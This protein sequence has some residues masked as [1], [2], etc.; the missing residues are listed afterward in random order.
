MRAP[1]RTAFVV[2][3]A[4][5]WTLQ[6]RDP[7]A[8]GYKAAAAPE[9]AEVLAVPERVPE[10][11]ADALR[12]VWDRM[13]P[14]RDYVVLGDPM[15]GEPAAGLLDGHVA[16]AHA[17]ADHEHEHHEDH[18]GDHEHGHGDHDG[19]HDHHDM[20]AI[21]GDPSADGLIMEAVDFSLGPF[22]PSLPGG[23]VVDLSL[24]GDVLARAR[25]RA[26]LLLGA[27]DHP[28]APLTWQV[29][30]ARAR[31]SPSESTGRRQIVA[32]EAERALSHALSLSALAS[33]MGWRDLSDAA[34]ELRRELLSLRG[35]GAAALAGTTEDVDTRGAERA[36]ARAARLL[37]RRSARARLARRG[38]LDRATVEEAKVG[39]PIGRATG[40]EDD[41]RTTDAL[42]AALD[43]TPETASA[44]DAAARVDVRVR[45]VAASLRLVRAAGAEE[46]SAGPA[47][48]SAAGLPVTVEGPRGPVMAIAAPD[49]QVAVA[50]PGAE[51]T[52]DLAGHAV[53][54][55]E[56]GPAMVALASFD[57]DPWRVEA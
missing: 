7:F 24:D 51:A 23:L 8:D 35:R 48:D 25:V 31:T 45:E 14:P 39:G 9:R 57:L 19:G 16:E 3:D 36:L 40:F 46:G 13:A 27:A 49:E 55:L 10:G 1:Q 2:P 53:V 4:A 44:G 34:Y 20:M 30:T 56:M 50:T 15:G 47:Q 6:G 21:V 29:A 52:L 17:H 41:A 42:Y 33:A 5:T 18:H 11:L 38:V 32:L 26:T 28:L 22:A 43:F 12:D 37:T 54:G